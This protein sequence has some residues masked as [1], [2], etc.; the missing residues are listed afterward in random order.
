[1]PVKNDKNNEKNSSPLEDYD[2]WKIESMARV[3]DRIAANFSTKRQRPWKEVTVFLSDLQ[4]NEIVLDLGC[5]NGRHSKIITKKNAQAICLDLS[6]NLLKVARNY[7]STSNEKQISLVNAEGQLLPFNDESFDRI[8]LIAV[9]HHLSTKEARFELV[10]EA[11]RVLKQDGMLFL[12][13]WLK[14]HPRFKKD[15]LRP[16]IEAGKKNVLVPWVL[17]N[18]KKIKRYYYLFNPQE[19]ISLIEKTN[20]QIIT[21]EI[22]YHNLYLTVQK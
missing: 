21:Q 4:K 16:Q 14:T 20:L 6:F 11:T 13:C 17:P 2:P 9:I 22:A 15:D 7:L 10:K 12:S 8:I 19:F 3:Y 18:G 5:G 1:M